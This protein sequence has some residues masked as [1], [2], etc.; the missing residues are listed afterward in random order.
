MEKNALFIGNMDRRIKVIEKTAVK[1]STGSETFTDVQLAAVWAERKSANS[2][3]AV[4]EKVV[5][6]NVVMYSIHWHPDVTNKNL[7]CLHVVDDEIEYEVYG[8][9]YVGRKKYIKLKCQIRE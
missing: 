3:K 2:D 5:A 8:F 7:Q 9:E 1:S 6:L 4:D